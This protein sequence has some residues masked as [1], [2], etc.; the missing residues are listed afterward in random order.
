MKF[1]VR[2]SSSVLS[3]RRST[4]P[5]QYARPVALLAATADMRVGR[6]I[7]SGPART[8]T[9]QSHRRVLLH[10]V[11]SGVLTGQRARADFGSASDIP[12]RQPAPLVAASESHAH[13]HAGNSQAVRATAIA[14]T[15]PTGT[16]LSKARPLAS[17]D[18]DRGAQAEHLLHGVRH[19]LQHV[20]NT[21]T[22]MTTTK[23]RQN[24][25]TE[26]C[27]TG[28]ARPLTRNRSNKHQ[29]M[30]RGFTFSS[31]RHNPMPCNAGAGNRFL[32]PFNA[33]KH[34]TTN[35]ET[36]PAPAAARP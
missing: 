19:P 12:K 35:E 23:T 13:A 16:T 28:P 1:A 25:K 26:S 36:N 34:S 27:T 9:E 32:S 17:F 4:G 3:P 8:L 6:S 31:H 11:A 5:A 22:Q 7:N 21:A 18:E 30:C 24:T 2:G 33:E 29:F 20:N 10:A 14:R 15:W